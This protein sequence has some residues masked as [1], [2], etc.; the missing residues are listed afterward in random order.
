VVV[1][2]GEESDWVR[3]VLAAGGQVVR[4]GR[5]YELLGARIVDP[6]RSGG[7]LPPVA[8]RYGRVTGKVLLGTLGARIG[9]FGPGPRS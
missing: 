1:L 4:G 3:N 5:T 2:Y 9:G 6:D 7:E 8:R